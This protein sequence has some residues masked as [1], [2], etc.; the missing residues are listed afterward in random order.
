MRALSQ[1]SLNF[2]PVNQVQQGSDWGVY[3][4]GCEKIKELIE[5]N[6]IDPKIKPRF[7]DLLQKCSSLIASL[8]SWYDV[9]SHFESIKGLNT[10]EISSKVIDTK[11]FQN[12]IYYHS[13]YHQF[14]L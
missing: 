1:E 13:I 9:I 2:L 11:D 12:K 10:Q 14:L 5:E 6:R 7:Q 4:R 3:K 8:E